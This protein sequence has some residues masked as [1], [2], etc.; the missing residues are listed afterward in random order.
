MKLTK[1]R[2]SKLYRKT[3]QSKRRFK[4]NKKRPVLRNTFRKRRPFDLNRKT[5]KR[6]RGGQGTTKEELQQQKNKLIALNEKEI[7]EYE[8]ESAIAEQTKNPD[9]MTK[10]IDVEN[11]RKKQHADKI[12]EINDKLAEIDLS[13][14][15]K[16]IKDA[17]GLETAGV[18]EAEEE[19]KD[20]EGLEAARVNGIAVGDSTQN[21]PMQIA[22]GYAV[23]DNE[24]ISAVNVQGEPIKKE[25]I[26]TTEIQNIQNEYTRKIEE[27]GRE[28]TQKLLEIAANNVT[29]VG[30][31]DSMAATTAVA[32]TISNTNL[33]GNTSSNGNSQTFPEPSAPFKDLSIDKSSNKIDQ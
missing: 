24:I 20:A 1:G 2:L 3:N 14:D 28:L 25:P 6:L 17:E 10:L 27:A 18:K 9:K 8:T 29:N 19:V 23:D 4:K 30:K 32:N 11:E 12:K 7:K 22:K 13:V 15:A 31:Q 16:E 26:Q 5:L 33:S 21:T